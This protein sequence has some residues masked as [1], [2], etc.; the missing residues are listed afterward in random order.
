[1]WKP[2]PILTGS[3][4]LYIVYDLKCSY[5]EAYNS[6]SVFRGMTTLI[7]A[8]KFDKCSAVSFRVDPSTEPSEVVVKTTLN[9]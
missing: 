1:M 5:W 2:E 8:T 6:A 3:L 4:S 9:S 7:F